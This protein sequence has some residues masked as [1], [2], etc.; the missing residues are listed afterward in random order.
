MA[1]SPMNI[2]AGFSAFVL[3]GAIAWS[4][5]YRDTPPAPIFVRS[6]DTKTVTDVGG[7]L[8][9]TST[10][11]TSSTSL[12]D[13]VL[14]QFAARYQALSASGVSP[15]TAAT[16]AADIVPTIVSTTY[17]ERDIPTNPDTSLAAVIRYRS[18][19]REALAP[20][21]ANTTPEL[22]VF[23][24]WIDTG[25]QQY[26]NELNAIADSYDTAIAQAKLVKTPIDAVHYQAGILNAMAQFSAALRAL[27]NHARDPIA[28]LTLLR[29]YNM[30][31]Q[32]MFMAFNSLG[33]YA[34]GKTST[35]TTP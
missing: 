17:A 9:P 6:A 11:A 28:S 35:T 16:Q 26:L 32:Q 1:F 10:E 27:A 30:A 7:F 2:I 33:I 34:S 29:T 3:T 13:A 19:L 25:D 20:L 23:A 18:D 15:D 4:A 31:E 12:G 8:Q 21:L 5:L 22:D 14:S 24:R